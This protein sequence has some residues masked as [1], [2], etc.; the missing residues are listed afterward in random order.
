MSES[1]GTP[2][3]GP[4]DSRRA[5]TETIRPPADQTNAAKRDHTAVAL[6]LILPAYNE[7]RRL[8][9]YLET[10]RHYLDAQCT[11]SLRSHCRR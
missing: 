3:C 9:P 11:N 8:P 1:L 2:A 4:G 7:S 5:Q 10:I 6:S